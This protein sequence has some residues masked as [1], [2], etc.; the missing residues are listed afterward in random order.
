MSSALKSMMRAD[1]TL[2][3]EQS[4]VRAVAVATKLLDAGAAAGTVRADIQGADLLRAVGGICMPTDP[5]RSEAAE[6]LVAVSRSR[7]VNTQGSAGSHTPAYNFVPRAVGVIEPFSLLRRINH[8]ATL[9][10]QNVSKDMNP[11]TG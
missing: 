3:F 2:V 7:A 1:A 4:R 5:E 8:I 11:R 9:S 10:G 6:R